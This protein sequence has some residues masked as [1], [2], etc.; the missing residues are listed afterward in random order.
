MEFR[1]LF[2]RIL[3]SAIAKAYFTSILGVIS[4]LFM[5]LVFVK[6]LT[7][8][9]SPLEFSLYGFIFQIVSYFMIFQLGLDYAISRE[10]SLNLGKADNHTANQAYWFIRRFNIRIIAIAALSIIVIAL[11][12][13]FGFGLQKEYDIRTS[14]QLV[15]LFGLS[16][17]ITFSVVPNIAA[18]IG[19]NLQ[20]LANL[21]NV[22]INILSTL[23]GYILL[24][25]GGGIYSL[26]IALIFW[27]F[28]NILFLQWNVKKRCRW[29]QNEPGER[30]KDLEKKTIRF[31]IA[32]TL[33]GLAWTI[34]A[35]SDV[36]ILNSAGLLN[37]VGIYVIWWRF[38][39]MLF[40]L[41]TR[42]TTS[43]T[44]GFALA[45]GRS[46]HESKKLFQ[47]VLLMI[48]GGAL[49]VAVGIALWLPSFIQIWINNNEYY[50]PNYHALSILMAI[51]VFF[52][53]VGN[54]LG[55]YL[56]SIGE[57]SITT[58]LSW[59]QAIFKVLLGIS[60][61]HYFSLE[62]IFWASSITAFLQVTFLTGYL[63]VRKII[64]FKIIAWLM[65]MI[66]IGGSSFF[67]MPIET[68]LSLFLAKII[69]TAILVGIMWLASVNI[70]G[71][72]KLLGFKTRKLIK[73]NNVFSA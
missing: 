49:I 64:P 15:L 50:Y 71:Y 25:N 55:M 63:I 40:D 4:G 41:I 73:G 39:Q 68:N 61:V 17:L 59:V 52:R 72:E 5:Q 19:S 26:P 69:A 66:L 33:G 18:L 8:M 43:S 67:Y 29:L 14:V 24:L 28:C 21:N 62:G 57:V 47:K 31:S 44:P 46:E 11:F 1:V 7:K 38:P 20:Y 56:I 23:L 32:T 2:R 60:L 58:R 13:H 65:V 10:I 42:F 6:A 70:F 34:E 35:T 27:G 51:L 3:Q 36:I 9:V 22:V 12:F 48:S 37:L 16:Q 45:H 53:I 30:N 54:C